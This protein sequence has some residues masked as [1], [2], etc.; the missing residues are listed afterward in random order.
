MS[1]RCDV[2]MVEKNASALESGY[3]NVRLPGEL[4]KGSLIAT[5]NS[6]LQFI[7]F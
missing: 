4:A 6:L 5:D 2:L 7:G 1:R 3:A